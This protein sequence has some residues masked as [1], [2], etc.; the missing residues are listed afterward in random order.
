MTTLNKCECL[1]R[2]LFLKLNDYFAPATRVS[3]NGNPNRDTYTETDWLTVYPTNRAILINKYN[4]TEYNAIPIHT[5]CTNV[6]YSIN[7][8]FFF[9]Q[10]GY[11]SG[12][13][14]NEIVGA[15]VK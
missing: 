1:R 11:L 13:P 4:M 6:P 9:E 14:L 3:K 2:R 15:Y 10:V 7:V 12:D 8:F 5:N